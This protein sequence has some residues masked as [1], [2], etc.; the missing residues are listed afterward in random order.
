[1]NKQYKFKCPI[2]SRWEWIHNPSVGYDDGIW[3]ISHNC[4]FSTYPKFLGNFNGVSAPTLQKL[5]KLLD[6]LNI[7]VAEVCDVLKWRKNDFGDCISNEVLIGNRVH[8]Y[9]ISHEYDYRL[10]YSPPNPPKV[11]IWRKFRSVKDELADTLKNAKAACQ[12]DFNKRRAK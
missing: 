3:R 12:A 2:C 4:T 11:W 9:Y 8:R 10:K 7:E 5:L 6:K 1:M